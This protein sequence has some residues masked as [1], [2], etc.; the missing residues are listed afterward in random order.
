M[1]IPARY[2]NKSE[3]FAAAEIHS[4]LKCPVLLGIPWM[5]EVSEG[6]E[7]QKYSK[8]PDV[9]FWLRFSSTQGSVGRSVEGEE[10][11]RTTSLSGAG[12]TL[13]I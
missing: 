5:T 9:R 8:L 7:E 13:A 10:E 4:R 12:P 2:G 6:Q 3:E 1:E 11:G